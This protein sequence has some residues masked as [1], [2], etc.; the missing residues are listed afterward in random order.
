MNENTSSV[1]RIRIA[2]F[3]FYCCQG[4]I[5][6]SWASRIP[7]LK[8]GL[9]M[10]DS[11]WGTMLLMRALGQAIGMSMSGFIV[12]K[13][14]SK[15]VLLMSLP[16][17]ALTLIPIALATNTYTFIIALI[18]SGI[19]SNFLNIAVN[20]QGIAAEAMYDKSIMSSF[21]GG[22]SI[23]G[24]WGVVIGL[25]M[26]KL[27]IS[28]PHQFLGVSILVILVALF[29]YK[30]LP[31]ENKQNAAVDKEN[32]KKIKPEKFL[33]IL[34]LV[35]FCGMFI[36]GTMFDWSGIYFKEIVQVQPSLVL[37]G[38]AGFMIMMATGRFVSDKVADK[39]GR[40][41]VI[42]ICGLCSFFGLMIAIL[43]PYLITATIGFM[44]I[45]LG[46]SS[47]VPMVYSIA[48]QKTK[49]PSGLALTVVASIG[50]L[51][52]L[53]GP[54]LIGYISSAANLKYSFAVVSAFALIIIILTSK[55]KIFRK[56]NGK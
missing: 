31:E 23:G 34:G 50:F 33:Y 55:I 38:F 32:R 40:P 39:W 42:K 56:D 26:I 17:A 18:V 35:A 28:P 20:A 54:P 14:G 25:F 48:G 15:K 4:L 47:I 3:I 52:F 21:H 41:F 43:F 27:N 8:S 51:G 49:M 11:I 1:K 16:L 9:G 19:V 12:S 29:N 10:D 2:V 44:L 46:T 5:F 24:F 53:M 37:V 6:A 13:F 45:G 22:W 7:D 30:Y 36:E